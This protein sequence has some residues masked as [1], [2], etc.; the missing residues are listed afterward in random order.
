MRAAG[1]METGRGRA[2]DEPQSYLPPSVCAG[3]CKE[4]KV[5]PVHYDLKLVPVHYDLKLVPVL[6]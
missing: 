5:E 4:Y 2:Q 6:P 3:L 1:A